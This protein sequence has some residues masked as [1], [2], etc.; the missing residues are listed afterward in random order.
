LE[1]EKIIQNICPVPGSSAEKLIEAASV[2]ELPK[3]HLLFKP[4][5]IETAVYFIRKGIARGFF[6]LEG[7]ERTFWFG[8]EGATVLSMLNYVQ[9]KPSY[10]YIELLEPSLLYRL[11][12]EQL[13]ELYASDIHLANWGRKL[14]ELELIKTEERLLSRQI[15]T[16][17]ERYKTLIQSDPGLLRRVS[18]GHIAS[19]L[20]ITQVSLSR[21]RAEIKD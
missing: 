1:L 16:S 5:Q 9:N 6:L 14:A 3:G 4:N 17:V 20:G 11:K 10:E 19:Y 13:K 18:L 15:K 12:S 7:D 8:Q 21:I 2:V